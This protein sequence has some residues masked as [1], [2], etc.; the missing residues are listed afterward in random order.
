MNENTTGYCSCCAGLFD[1]TTESEEPKKLR[2]M[3]DILIINFFVYKC[4]R[5]ARIFCGGG[6]GGGCVPQ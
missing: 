3:G 5:V 2:G 1:C 4:R 6:G